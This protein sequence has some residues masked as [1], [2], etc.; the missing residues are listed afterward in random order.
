MQLAM[1][2]DVELVK[3]LAQLAA[4]FIKTVGGVVG[5]VVQNPF[6]NMLK[7]LGCEK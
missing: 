1:L 6:G 2:K 3:L 7:I 4:R 5:A